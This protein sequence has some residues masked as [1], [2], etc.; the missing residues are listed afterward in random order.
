MGKRQLKLEASPKKAACSGLRLNELEG[1]GSGSSPA[2]IADKKLLIT[3]RGYG[4]DASVFNPELFSKKPLY[5]FI[6]AAD[7]IGE[8]RKYLYR[9][10]DC[11]TLFFEENHESD[12]TIPPTWTVF[13][14]VFETAFQFVG[15]TH[16]D[17]D[18]VGHRRGC[19]GFYTTHDVKEF[20]TLLD[21]VFAY[22]LS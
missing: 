18:D 1:T 6:F 11:M 15:K 13:E 16:K 3:I 21:D 9:L 2:L 10:K 22:R 12:D 5:Q 20:L 14:Q 19:S 7:M 17:F 4:I 8:T